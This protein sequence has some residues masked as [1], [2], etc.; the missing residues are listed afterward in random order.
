MERIYGVFMVKG[1][2][3][4]FEKFIEDTL[5]FF[6][7]IFGDDEVFFALGEDS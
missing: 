4:V 6:R 1:T 5:Q 3:A 7:V 2:Y